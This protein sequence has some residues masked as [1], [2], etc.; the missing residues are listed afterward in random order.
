MKSAYTRRAVFTK[1]KKST[2]KLKVVKEINPDRVDE[3][4]L[5]FDIW[6]YV[7]NLMR[8]RRR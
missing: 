5:N 8:C 6:F 1:G 7:R 3:K 2:P 4:D